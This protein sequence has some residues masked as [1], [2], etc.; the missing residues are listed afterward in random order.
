M[1]N[2]NCTNT[3]QTLRN[4]LND[5][6]RVHCIRIQLRKVHQTRAIT[7]GDNYPHVSF[8]PVLIAFSI[9]NK[10]KIPQ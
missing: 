9:K 8:D 1:G 3:L 6:Q 4:L 2:K 5:I 10:K 7:E